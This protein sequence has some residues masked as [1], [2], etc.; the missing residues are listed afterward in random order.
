M[1]WAIAIK[2]NKDQQERSDCDNFKR[3]LQ[4][5]WGEKVTRLARNILVT[6]SFTKDIEIP[7]PGDIR[8]LVIL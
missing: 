4:I 1:K 8:D 5:E 3:L 7:T 6:R 2:T